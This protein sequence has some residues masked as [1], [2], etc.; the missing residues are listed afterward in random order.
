[1][2]PIYRILVLSASAA[3]LAG[4]AAAEE[5]SAQSAAPPA[6]RPAVRHPAA[7]PPVRAVPPAAKP[8][9]AAPKA[10]ALP[11]LPAQQ[12]AEKY[13]AARGGAAWKSVNTLTFKGKMGAG[14]STYEAVTKKLTLERREREEMQL[15]FVLEAKRPNKSRLELTFNGQTAVQVFDGAAG[16]KY[17]PFLN[18]TDWQPYSA[19]ELQAARAEPGIDGWLAS[20]VAEGARV[21]ADGTEMVGDQACYRLKVTRSA[22]APRH[23][24]IDAK[25]FL[26]AKEEGDPRSLDGRPHAVYVLLRDYQA[27]NGLEIAHTLET[28]VQGVPKSEKMTIDAVAVNPPLDDARF[29]R[30]R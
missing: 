8:V 20:A 19:T 2:R 3:L 9:A 12:I 4:V 22:G 24:W 15:P 14:A 1:M 17:R 25:T 6:A 13:M 26:E 7:K 21:D 28:V 11:P 10:P 29:T 30:P 5:P 23:V 16:Y 27:H 18:R